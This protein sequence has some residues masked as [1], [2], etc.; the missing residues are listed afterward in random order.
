MSLASWEDRGY[1]AMRQAAEKAQRQLHRL[2]R[3]ATQILKQPSFS[4]ILQLLPCCPMIA[5]VQYPFQQARYGNPTIFFC[6]P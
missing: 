2:A 1:Y 3:R 4:G 5:A 6:F